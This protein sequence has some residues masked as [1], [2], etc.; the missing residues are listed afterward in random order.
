MS[1]QQDASHQRLASLLESLPEEHRNAVSQAFGNDQ[2]AFEHELERVSLYCATLESKLR[3]QST[4]AF[5][6]NAPAGADSKLGGSQRLR[7]AEAERAEAFAKISKLQDELEQAKGKI[8]DSALQARGDLQ[9][10]LDAVN[11]HG[12]HMHEKSKDRRGR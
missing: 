9:S 1:T 4:T 2:A 11:M 8:H 3:G 6:G 10:M 7:V 5:G 12:V